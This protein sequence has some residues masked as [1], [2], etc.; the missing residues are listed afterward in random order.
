VST[1]GL[2]P[3]PEW[4]ASDHTGPLARSAYHLAA[5][6]APP[7]FPGDTRVPTVGL[8]LALATGSG[9]DPEPEISLSTG[10]TNIP[11][12]LTIGEARALAVA[13]ARAAAAAAAHL[14][15]V[16]TVCGD[17]CRATQ[18]AGKCTLCAFRDGGAPRRLR[19]V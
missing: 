6:S 9:D 17:P 16:C 10:S 7:R 4:C 1:L 8:T 12:G 14:P 3:C 15:D 11:L 18:H 13:L 19:L 2:S 5:W